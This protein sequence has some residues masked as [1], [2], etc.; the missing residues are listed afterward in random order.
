MPGVSWLNCLSRI[1]KYTNARANARSYCD[2]PPE[3][4]VHRHRACRMRAI[5]LGAGHGSS[6][7]LPRPPPPAPPT[8]WMVPKRLR[9]SLPSGAWPKGS[10][11][12]GVKAPLRVSGRTPGFASRRRSP[13]GCRRGASDVEGRD[14]VGAAGRRGDAFGA[15]GGSVA[16][17]LAGAVADGHT[18]RAGAPARPD[19]DRVAGAASRHPDPAAGDHPAPA[20]P[21]RADTRRRISPWCS[22]GIPPSST[23]DPIRH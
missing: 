8:K 21:G 7:G 18:G 14:G 5:N 15:Q 1:D 13:P 20:L 11:V 2:R 12:Q 9:R 19:A 17:R 22:R 10:A 6:R 16:A 3:G 23:P 4:L